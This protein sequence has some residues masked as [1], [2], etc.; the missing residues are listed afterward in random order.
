MPR[1][2]DHSTCAVCGR[3]GTGLGYSEPR[4]PF[5]PL[6][7]CDDPDCIQI[8]K[9]SYS[10]PQD[11]FNRIERM[12]HQDAGHALERYCDRIG[13]TDFRDFT[14]DEFEG[15]MESVFAEYHEAMKGRLKNEA[16]F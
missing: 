8:A 10:M 16:P 2:S 14:Q 5:R 9:D 11:D 13:K 1:S 15:A 6:W 3:R 12:A 4:Q 7:L